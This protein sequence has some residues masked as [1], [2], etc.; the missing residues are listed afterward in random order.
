[1]RLKK[2]PI[3]L[4]R[5]T[6][7]WL[8][9]LWLATTADRKTYTELGVP[10]PPAGR[11]GRHIDSVTWILGLALIIGLTVGGWGAWDWQVAVAVGGVFATNSY[12]RQKFNLTGKKMAV[13]VAGLL[14]SL[15]MVD[16]L[17]VSMPC[18]AAALVILLLH[19]IWTLVWHQSDEQA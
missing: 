11:L 18:A 13:G 14:I 17:G 2:E 1:M 5:L 12:N 7:V 8:Q 10:V 6:K 4:R 16:A 19:L 9:M 3:S 15:G